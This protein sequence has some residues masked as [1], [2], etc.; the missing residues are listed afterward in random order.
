MYLFLSTIFNFS[1]LLFESVT[2]GSFKGVGAHDK[3]KV[4]YG[5]QS[6]G[7]G[8]RLFGSRSN[9]RERKVDPDLMINKLNL[10]PA[11]ENPD[12]MQ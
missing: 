12:K 6:S 4:G 10:D 11:V 2:S 7:Y 3:D 8:L 1:P 9:S 5:A